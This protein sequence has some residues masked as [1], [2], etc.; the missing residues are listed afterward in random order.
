MIKVGFEKRRSKGIVEI[1]FH[2]L[3]LIDYLEAQIVETVQLAKFEQSAGSSP[4]FKIID[5]LAG[6]AYT[7]TAIVLS[8]SILV[9]GDYREAEYSSTCLAEGRDGVPWEVKQVIVRT[10]DWPKLA[11][12]LEFDHDDF[13]KVVNHLQKKRQIDAVVADL[14]VLSF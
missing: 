9:S 11:K 14:M 6:I 7:A 2:A 10:A 8:S 12:T 1:D 5:N 3:G 13:K 4:V